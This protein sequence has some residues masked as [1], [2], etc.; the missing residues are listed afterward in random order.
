MASN[1]QLVKDLYAAFGR[2]D[3]PAVLGAMDE[4]IDWQEPESLPFDDQIGPQAVAENIFGPVTTLLQNFSVTPAEILDAGE[5]VVAIGAYRG[6][7]A[8][9]GKDLD[10]A[11]THVWRIKDGKIAGFRTYTDTHQWL[12]VLGKA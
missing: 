9:T 12:E 7:G 11:F 10:A 8:D 3:V 5:V 2:G 4:K 6:T 1:V